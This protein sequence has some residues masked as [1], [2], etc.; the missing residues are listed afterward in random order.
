MSRTTFSTPIFLAICLISISCASLPAAKN[1]VISFKGRMEEKDYEGAKKYASVAFAQ[2]IDGY[3]QIEAVASS[4][5]PSPSDIQSLGGMGDMM[6]LMSDVNTISGLTFASVK[7]P[8]THYVPDLLKGEIEK[9]NARVWNIDEDYI[10]YILIKEK[11]RWVLDGF[12]VSKL[13]EAAGQ[14]SGK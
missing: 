6:S 3:K 4:G 13:S 9:D 11:G 10:V 1:A 5:N 2:K 14:P 7:S 8:I 12:D